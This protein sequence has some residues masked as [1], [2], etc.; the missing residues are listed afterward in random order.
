MP[1]NHLLDNKFEFIYQTQQ[2]ISDINELPYWELEEY[3]LR[4][5]KKN[6]E[7]EKQYKKQNEEYKKQQTSSGIGNFNP[8]SFMRKFK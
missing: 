6:E 3:I 1:L 5:N 4:L 8:N 2:P 7:K